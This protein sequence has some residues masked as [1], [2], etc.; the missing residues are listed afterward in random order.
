MFDLATPKDSNFSDTGKDLFNIME[1]L[2]GNQRLLKLLLYSTPGA[3][4][5]DDLTDEEK[6][7]L[8]NNNIK[9]TPEIVLPDNDGSLVIVAFD[10]FVPN[11]TNPQFRDNIINFDIVCYLKNWLMDDYMLRPYKIM[12]EIDKMFNESKLNGIGKVKFVSANSLILSS[13]LAGF[14]LTYRVINDV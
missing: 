4:L 14:T 5:E 3:L 12:H 6:G 11:E 7:S 1:R 8:I 9:V 13:D 2:L 10:G